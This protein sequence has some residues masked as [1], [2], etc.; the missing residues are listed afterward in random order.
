MAKL[1]RK[2]LWSHRSLTI[3][4]VCLGLKRLCGVILRKG[5][6]ASFRLGGIDSEKVTA[7][8]N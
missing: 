5:I 8:L 4:A 2:R 7:R 6:H 1:G 3:A